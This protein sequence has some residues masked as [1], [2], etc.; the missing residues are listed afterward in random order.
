MT[1]LFWA[2]IFD[3]LSVVYV[4]RAVVG[5]SWIR[6]EYVDTIWIILSIIV[7]L[8]GSMHLFLLYFVIFLSKAS[9]PA[10]LYIRIEGLFRIVLLGIIAVLWLLKR[11]PA[12]SQLSQDFLALVQSILFTFCAF[13]CLFSSKLR[14]GSLIQLAHHQRVFLVA[15]IATFIPLMIGGLVFHWLENWPFSQAWNFVNVS[16][17][18]IGYGNTVPTRVASKIFLVLFGNI[19]IAMVAVLI[20]ALRACFTVRSTWRFIVVLIA[21]WG[22]GAVIF[23]FIEH[24]SFINSLYF[25]WVTLTTI[26]YGD[27]Y[28]TTALAWEFWL[29]YVYIMVCLLAY[30]IGLISDAMHGRLKKNVVTIPNSIVQN[31]NG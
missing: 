28:P 14:G 13:I 18:T 29:L 8:S 9:K 15:M 26:G 17:L 22:F 6:Q 4:L 27:F 5:A 1:L 31:T 24:W 21:F 2:T 25:V 16:S 20:A 3:I 11:R 12:F 19:M 7:F 23:M 10:F 30:F